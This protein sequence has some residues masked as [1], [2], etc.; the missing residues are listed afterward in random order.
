MNIGILGCGYISN[1]YIENT[2]YLNNIN[3]VGCADLN[4]SR[5][6]ETSV[7]HGISCYSVSELINSAK[8]DLILNL[9]PPKAHFN[10]CMAVVAAGKHVYVE[11][12]LSISSCQAKEL[13]NFADKSGVRVGVA[14]DTFMG[15]PIQTAKAIIDDGEI[16]R[17]IGVNAFM[18]K[19][20]PEK[21]H[22][23]PEFFYQHGSGPMYD[24][25]PYYVTALV[26]LLGPVRSV[27][28]TAG[29]V[30]I[31]REIAEG[32]KKG[33]KINV[34]TPTHISGSLEFSNGVVG[35][36]VT[37]FDVMNTALPKYRNLWNW[38]DNHYT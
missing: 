36:L 29:M 20:G 4:N 12:P 8:V 33:T 17:P 32:Y 3:I 30:P 31:D 28:A 9:T 22:P 5:A 26:H 35:T 25:G 27:S 15:D 24:M 23:D 7:R 10:S 21:W 14:P 13:L 19:S 34:E 6:L 1:V 37:S 38:R 2:S 11:K 18:L 16:G